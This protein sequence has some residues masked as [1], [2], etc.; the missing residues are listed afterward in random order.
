MEGVA[1][2]VAVVAQH[3]FGTVVD[4]QDIVF[5]GRALVIGGDRSGVAHSPEE[6]LGDGRTRLVG[7]GHR[8]EVFALDARI[9]VVGRP[10]GE[11]AAER[12]GGGVELQAA[13]NM[14]DGVDQ[15]V[16]VVDVAEE[17]GQV[18]VDDI[19]IHVVLVLQGDCRGSVIGA[20]NLDR[21]RGGAGAAFTVRNGI[22]DRAG[23]RLAGSQVL[24][25]VARV[26]RVRAVGVQ[27][28][29]ATVGTGGRR[30]HIAAGA[31]DFR[32]RQFVAVRVD[33]VSQNAVLGVDVERG[34]LVRGAVI[35]GRRRGGVGDVPVEFLG[36]RGAGRVGCGDRDGVD[37][38]VA[39]LRGGM[40]DGA[41]DDTGVRIDGQAGRQARRGKGELVAGIRIRE[42]GGDVVA[43]AGLG[44]HARR[45][46]N[47]GRNGTV[48][49]AGDGHDHSGRGR[50]AAG[51]RNG[52]RDGAGGRFAHGQMAV[53]VARREDIAAVGEHREG[54]AIAAVDRDA[55]RR[56]RTAADRDDRQRIAIGIRVVRE[57]VAAHQAVLVAAGGVIQRI[58]RVVDGCRRDR[59]VFFAG[60]AGTRQAGQHIFAAAGVRVGEI[61]RS[62]G[63]QNAGQAHEAAAAGIAAARHDGGS[64]I[65]FIERVAAVTQRGQEAVG[66]GAG[67]R[68][69]RGFGGVGQGPRH[70]A[71][72]RDFAA[73][74]DDDR[75]AVLNLKRNRGARRSDDVAACGDLAT[76]MQFGQRAVAIAYPRATGDF[77]D[78]CG[79]SVG[80]VGSVS[81]SYPRWPDTRLRRRRGIL[82][83]RTVSGSNFDFGVGGSGNAVDEQGELQ[84][85]G[86]TQLFEDG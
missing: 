17:A 45:V 2:G 51:I 27:G 78:D 74:A 49:G 47:G 71:I 61:Q 41:G 30:A 59:I 9:G 34:V 19:P 32:D 6:S 21:Q 55:G 52:V 39:A 58:G 25:G 64:G 36:G 77:V 72:D 13:R 70:F 76:L 5:A 12:A 66:V 86:Y 57:Q 75:H 18:V 11:L 42:M 40:I 54:A 50:G 1:I 85:V 3:A 68:G 48:V 31:V 37:A 60:G 44:V 38:V 82:S 84:A 63:F 4:D 80:H 8:D 7:G 79:R 56:H 29:R 22:G 16:A 24:E 26:E 83:S 35:V 53:L 62:G 28:E 10:V 65:Q 20:G 81:G 43:H 33:V 69:H 73:F 46:G 14:V 15:G 23:C 67:G